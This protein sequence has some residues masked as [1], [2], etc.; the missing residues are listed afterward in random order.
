MVVTIEKPKIKINFDEP[1]TTYRL[2]DGS[3]VV[4]VTTAINML[5]KPALPMWG[6]NTGK[7]P[8]YKNLPEAIEKT[9]TKCSKLKKVDAMVWAFSMGQIRKYASLYG[10]RD[11]AADIGTIAHA[12]LMAR[13]TG[14]EIDNS[15]ITPDNWLLAEECVKSHDKWFEGQDIKTIF[16]EKE[17]V[18]QLYRYGGKIDKYAYVTREKTLIDYK[19]GK[20]I[21]DEYFIQLIGYI[22][23][24][25]ENGHE[26]TRAIL[27]NMPKTKG[28]NFKVD[29]RSVKSLFAAGYFEKFL[30][31][32]DTYYADQK[33]K[34][35]KE[36]L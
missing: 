24:L 13:D 19:S 28:D 33:I 16:V 25:L 5:N 4:G 20:D 31:L 2:K 22:Q 1:H 15:N 36:V 6:F 9:D 17:M 7:E 23:L 18:S 3:V 12:I 34:A 8:A 26:V 14:F 10:N 30:G 32:R 11:K 29:S 35:Y 27:V 21:F